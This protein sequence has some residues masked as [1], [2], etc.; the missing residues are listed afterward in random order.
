[1]AKSFRLCGPSD[2][3]RTTVL[4]S[5][6]AGQLFGANGADMPSAGRL[7]SGLAESPLQRLIL[8]GKRTLGTAQIFDRPVLM[9]DEA[10]TS[11]PRC[12]RYCGN[13]VYHSSA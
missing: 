1:M 11:I 12:T 3:E 8:G 9:N 6:A 2:A 13:G 7:L 4:G 5:L 10:A